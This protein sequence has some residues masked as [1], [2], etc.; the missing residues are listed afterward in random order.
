MQ[1]CDL[2]MKRILSSK[3]LYVYVNQYR[4]SFEAKPGTCM[5]QLE[6][7]ECRD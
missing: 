1:A 3:Q 5:L 4:Q 7:C 2:E 6:Y